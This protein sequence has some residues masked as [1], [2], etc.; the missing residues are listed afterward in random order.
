MQY[1]FSEA[2]RA[3]EFY[4]AANRTKSNEW[5]QIEIGNPLS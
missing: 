2:C 3:A 4:L 1:G 5:W